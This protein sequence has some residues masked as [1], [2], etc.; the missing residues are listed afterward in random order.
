MGDII[1]G[2]LKTSECHR[3]IR[4]QVSL[5]NAPLNRRLNCIF[6]RRLHSTLETCWHASA[7]A[8][9]REC[10]LAIFRT[11][12]APPSTH[13]LV[14]NSDH[15]AN[16]DEIKLSAFGTGR[17]ETLL[18]QKRRPNARRTRD[19]GTSARRAICSRSR[20]CTKDASDRRPIGRGESLKEPDE[21]MKGHRNGNR[22]SMYTPNEL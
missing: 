15:D 1:R 4:N 6:A 17:N 16:C 14:S 3:L 19:G 12:A 13:T 7:A 8:A 9:R 18:K 10:A 5:H 20:R 21:R 22:H 11:A 2:K